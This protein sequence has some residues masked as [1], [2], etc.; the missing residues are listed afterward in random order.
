V[1]IKLTRDIRDATRLL[2]PGPVALI[3]SSFRSS[4]NVM[5]AAWMMPA[6]LEPPLLAVAIFP[7]RLTHEYVSKSE[8]FAI[9]IP[10]ADL[11][12][13]VHACGML[14]GRVGDKFVAAGL[15]PIDA[16]QLEVPLIEECVA[17][18][19]CGVVDRAAFGDHDLF[20]AQP[21]AVVAL[22]EAFN[23]RWLVETDAGQ[24]IHHLRADYYAT[25]SRP[26][27]A[28]LDERDE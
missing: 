9:N 6:S 11:L 20:I 15:T 27:Q 21:L 17:H 4:D 10:N 8:F 23:E 22:D 16:T 3:T 24:T 5:T 12:S 14:T 28:K 13:A 1:P 2:E 18:I 26:Y 25:L 19:E 7:G